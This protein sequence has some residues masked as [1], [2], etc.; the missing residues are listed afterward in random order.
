MNVVKLDE[1]DLVKK[2]LL[3]FIRCGYHTTRIQQE[4]KHQK[5]GIKL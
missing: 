5:D 2:A 4:D 1:R 3:L